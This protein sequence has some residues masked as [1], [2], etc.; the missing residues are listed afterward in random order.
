MKTL[1]QAYQPIAIADGDDVGTNRSTN[2]PLLEIVEGRMSRRTALKA[3][4]TTAAAGAVG[5]TLTSRFALAA[6]GD[7]STLGFQSLEQVI[8]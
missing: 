1:D 3:F 8:T 4:V 6:E 5:G 2:R 7:P